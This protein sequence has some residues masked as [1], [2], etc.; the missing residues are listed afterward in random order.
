MTEHNG[1]S[2]KVKGNVSKIKG[3]AK[4]QI[5][6]VTD[7]HSLQAEGKLDKVKGSIQQKIGEAK[8]K[9]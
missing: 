1:M 8:D 7:N 5:G 3:E 6:K 9:W 2:D 4:D